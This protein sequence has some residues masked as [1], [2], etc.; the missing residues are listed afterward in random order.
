[1]RLPSPAWQTWASLEAVA[2]EPP[3]EPLALRR[4][5]RLPVGTMPMDAERFTRLP[6]SA[7]ETGFL[8][9][10]I[11]EGQARTPASLGHDL[12]S[13]APPLAPFVPQSPHEWKDQQRVEMEDLASVLTAEARR[14]PRWT[15]GESVDHA[16]RSNAPT[17]IA[18]VIDSAALRGEGLSPE[19][20]LTLQPRPRTVVGNPSFV[21]G[22]I[23]AWSRAGGTGTTAFDRATAHAWEGVIPADINERCARPPCT[24]TIAPA[25]SAAPANGSPASPAAP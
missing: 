3:V 24:D 4:I 16:V 7:D 23:S 9:T 10:V 12:V 15:L 18:M 1:M 6:G 21:P 2:P 8:A 22:T 17:P 13:L 14:R 19:T 11:P 5:W 25:V 20:P